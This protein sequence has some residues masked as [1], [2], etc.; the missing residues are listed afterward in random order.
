ME[1]GLIPRIVDRAVANARVIRQAPE[2]VALVGIIAL[3]VSYSAFQQYH[4]DRVAALNDRVASQERLLTDYR[5][6]LNGAT[7]EE[8]A[9]QIEKLTSLLAETQK[10]LNEAKT[11]PLS[12]ENR[13]HDP[14]RL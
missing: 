14:Q 7:P 11:K 4:Q 2:T 1:H 3:G 9:G 13:S 5:T 6:K 8:A 12:V 10:T